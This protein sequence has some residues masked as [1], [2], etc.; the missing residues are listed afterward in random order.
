MRREQDDESILLKR[1]QGKSPCEIIDRHEGVF[2]LWYKTN[3]LSERLQ[4]VWA[5]A[6]L[7]LSSRQYHKKRSHNT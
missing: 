4:N 6:R 5:Y 7:F 1:F 2:R 3:I